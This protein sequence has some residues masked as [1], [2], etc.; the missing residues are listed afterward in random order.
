MINYPELSGVHFDY[1]RYQDQYFGFNKKGIEN[2]QLKYNFNP[3]DIHRG[4]FSKKFGWSN[5]ERDSINN[6]WLQ[7]KTDN[8]TEL[9]INLNSFREF[10]HLDIQ[11]SAAVKSN[12][13]E[14][15]T[16]W[17]QDWRFW[18]ENS[19]VDF[20]VPMN[21][22]INK[23]QFLENIK[24]INENIFTE[25]LDEKIIMGIS[26]YNQN[27]SDVADKMILSDLS[28]YNKICFFSYNTIKNRGN[29]LNSINSIY[30]KK[31]IY[32]RGVVR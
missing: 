15:K 16:R 20:V 21:Y 6:L 29:I 19:I 11:I 28:G 31:N 30:K 25:N 7:Y 23:N 9:L 32:F 26:L 17:Y 13:L 2:F 3:K 22:S 24:L 8:I 1:I 4:V 12:I 10:N 18:I 14:S 27:E 5:T